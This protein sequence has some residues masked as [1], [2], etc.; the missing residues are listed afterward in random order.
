MPWNWYCILQS[1]QFTKE[2]RIRSCN[3]PCLNQI[4]PFRFSFKFSNSIPSV[5]F[6]LRSTFF[7]FFFPFFFL[8][9]FFLFLNI[10]LFNLIFINIKIFSSLFLMLFKHCFIRIKIFPSK[11]I[12]IFHNNFINLCLT[13][14][15]LFFLRLC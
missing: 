12:L 10:F 13:L 9:L 2:K 15:N 4:R 7:H 5:L 11:Y 6:P 8:N 3:I 14:I 1:F